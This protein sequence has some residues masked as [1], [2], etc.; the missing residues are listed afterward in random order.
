M[1]GRVA[2]GVHRCP[3][4]GAWRS[5]SARTPCKCGTPVMNIHEVAAL[6]ACS[7]S[8]VN[9]LRY[10][11]NLPK[12]DFIDSHRAPWWEVARIQDWAASRPPIRKYTKPVRVVTVVDDV[13]PVSKL[14]TCPDCGFAADGPGMPVLLHWRQCPRYRPIPE[15]E[16]VASVPIR[17]RFETLA[18][19]RETL[20]QH[21][22]DIRVA[23]P[24][25]GMSASAVYGA[26]RR[27]RRDGEDV[28]WTGQP[29]SNR[30]TA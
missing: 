4:C 2:E 11:G 26:L 20:E 7:T 18:L 29:R 13:P 21:H 1:T 25:M 24:L 6:L 30:R 19:F 22:G 3:G 27:C 16:A 14:S 8:Q 5:D 10:R 15:R 17:S 28:S 12:E 23:A 9:R